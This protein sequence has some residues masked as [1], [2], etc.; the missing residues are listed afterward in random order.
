MSWASDKARQIAES[1]DGCGGFSPKCRQCRAIERAI[2]ETL[3]RC[4]AYGRT[5]ILNGGIR[6]GQEDIAAEE[7]AAAIRKLDE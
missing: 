5:F 4:A 3:V 1:D 6:Q 7:L 2:R